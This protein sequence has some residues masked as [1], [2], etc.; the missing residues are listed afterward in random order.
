MLGWSGLNDWRIAIARSTART[1][2]MSVSPDLGFG[3]GA[4]TI[5]PRIASEIRTV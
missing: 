3:L 1:L 5:H 2:D 4:F